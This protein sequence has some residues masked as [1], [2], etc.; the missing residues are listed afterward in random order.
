MA[1]PAVQESVLGDY[2]NRVAKKKIGENSRYFST[3]SEKKEATIHPCFFSPS[4]IKSYCTV[5]FLSCFFLF[6][7]GLS[8][9]IR[10]LE[11]YFS[12]FFIISPNKILPRNYVANSS[13]IWTRQ[14]KILQVEKFNNLLRR[15]KGGTIL[16][17]HRLLCT[18]NDV[19]IYQM[20]WK[21]KSCKI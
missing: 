4:L 17:L 11:M 14:M 21:R 13:L 1:P 2:T 7:E 8:L 10:I 18:A 12:P 20:V 9:K 19:L 6:S 15:K 16:L 5:I 3:H